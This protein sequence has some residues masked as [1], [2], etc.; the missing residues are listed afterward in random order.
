MLLADN[1]ICRQTNKEMNMVYL[2]KLSK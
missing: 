1:S 2:D